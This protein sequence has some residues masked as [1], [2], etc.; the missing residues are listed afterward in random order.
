[1]K[2]KR[3]HS[4]YIFVLFS[5]IFLFSI[6][7]IG[8]L[9][10]GSNAQGLK[11]KANF[12]WSIL[13]PRFSGIVQFIDVS[14]NKPISWEWEFGDGTKSYEQHPIH[15]YSKTGVYKVSLRVSN[16]YGV[17]RAIKLIFI[18]VIK[19]QT[20]DDK[21]NERFIDWSLAGIWYNG[22]KKKPVYQVIFCNVKENIPGSQLLAKG[23][24]ISD[25]TDAIQTALNLCPE[26][27]VVYL[28]RG[29]Y[30]LTRGLV[31]N[32]SIIIRGECD[33]N[34]YPLTELL[35]A[36]SLGSNRATIELLGHSS[37]PYTKVANVI[38][39]F[40][41]N[42][43]IIEVSNPEYFKEGQIV[44]LD[45][46]NNSYLVT[47]YGRIGDSG[48]LNQCNYA[49][50][51]EGGLRS[52]GETFLIKQVSA[53]KII[54]NRPLYWN[55]KSYLM[56]QLYVHSER[57]LYYAGVEN[58]HLKANDGVEDGSGIILAN[59]AYCWINNCE[60]ESFPR[61]AIWL[62]DGSYGCEI[63]H[64][65]IHNAPELN[66][67]LPDKRYGIFIY[68]NCSDNLIEDNIIHF[69]LAGIVLEVGNSGNV[70]AYNYINTTCYNK[71]KWKTSDILTHAPHNYM[72]LFEGNVAGT[73][74]FDIYWGSSSHQTVLRNWL[75]TRNPD[76]EVNQNRIAL[77]NGG[78]NRYDTIIGNVLGYP[79][80]VQVEN[81]PIYY[82]QIPFETNYEVIHLWKV[83][84]WSGAKGTP[85]QNG[86]P[87]TLATIIR[88]GNFDFVRNQIEWDNSISLR[89]IPNSLY[90]KSKPEW[91]GSLAWPAIGPDL[92]PPNGIIPAQWRYENQ[93]YFAP[94]Q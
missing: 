35:Q 89:T 56:P 74:E 92:S 9:S 87:L 46:L 78:W 50:R 22:V 12:K 33:Q 63:S 26:G 17:S 94:V 43:N 57:P 16:N 47:N 25:D 5:V 66:D 15:Y 54:I 1:M 76:W 31:I 34:N 88:H 64:N 60:I 6:N 10:Y 49:G 44:T 40:E 27:Q 65:Y 80:M 37:Y 61:R 83:G 32:K 55:F 58:L 45:E 4:V 41:K 39:G 14:A 69:V 19:Q 24:G 77:V 85:E 7:W 30:K 3:W 20:R 81:Y 21:L 71:N 62:K 2:G 67:F 91:F 38:G 59:C 90:L 29:I 73:L 11:P 75:H 23:D 70:I 82:E 36:A 13:N 68:G 86:D 48:S 28:P 72:N 42:S 84:F 8:L 53:N 52:Y 18:Y 51:I 93:K 79:G